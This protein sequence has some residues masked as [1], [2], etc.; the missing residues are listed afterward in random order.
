M[1]STCR[2]SCEVCKEGGEAEEATE[3]TCVDEEGDCPA[4]AENG[5][6]QASS[7]YSDYMELN[8][9]KSCGKCGEEEEGEGGDIEECGGG[10]NRCSDG[11]CKHIHMC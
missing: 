1:V 8:C 2:K 4:W 11:S 3:K 7:I 5:F 9:E 10:L 6:C